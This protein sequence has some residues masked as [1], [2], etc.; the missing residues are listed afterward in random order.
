[1]STQVPRLKVYMPNNGVKWRDMGH[2][3]KDQHRDDTIAQALV[4]AGALTREGVNTAITKVFE[5]ALPVFK[6]EDKWTEATVDK[7]RSQVEWARTLTNT[8]F[9]AFFRRII[10]ARCRWE[11][12]K[13]ARDATN[14]PTSILA[15]IAF[16]QAIETE[17]YL[18]PMAYYS[19]EGLDNDKDDDEEGMD[20]MFSD[21]DD[22]DDEYAKPADNSG[23]RASVSTRLQQLRA[24]D[25]QTSD[26]P[27]AGRLDPEEEGRL[28][29]DFDEMDIDDPIEVDE[30]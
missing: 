18:F 23:L 21:D 2:I 11:R 7:V 25:A 1:M 8:V 12:L 20:D 17:S 3:T 4:S 13:T 5:I 16:R 9:W 14:H 10:A 27:E 6:E 22:D 19:V 28:A 24:E 29:R 30:D 15:V 26:Q